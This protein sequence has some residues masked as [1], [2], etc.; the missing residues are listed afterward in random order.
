[1]DVERHRLQY[2]DVHALMRELKRIGARNAA[3]RRERA[4]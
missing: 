4:G 3:Q 1:M 2:P